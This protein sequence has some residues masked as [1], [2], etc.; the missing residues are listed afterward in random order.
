MLSALSKVGVPGM[1]L[2]D[3]QL[4]AIQGRV[5]MATNGYAESTAMKSYHLHLCY[6]STLERLKQHLALTDFEAT[7]PYHCMV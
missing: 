3:E 7:P 2:K 5:C 1:V 4:M 6:A